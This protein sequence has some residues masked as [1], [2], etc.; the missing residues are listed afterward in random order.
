MP[1]GK[2]ICIGEEWNKKSAAEA[3]LDRDAG[4]VTPQIRQKLL[5]WWLDVARGANTPNWDLASTCEIEGRQGLLLV[6]AKAHEKELSEKGKEKPDTENG[7]KNHKRIGLAINEANAGLGRATGG[8]WGLSRD[9][10][11][12]L[13]NR[14]AWS[15][16]LALLGVPVV[17]LY[18]GFL[19]AED[20]AGDGE[21]FRSEGDWARAM[22]E[23][24]RG[25]VDDSCWENRLDVN[26][27]TL[28]PLMRVI[29]VPF[30]PD[31]DR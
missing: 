8:S 3:R 29:G 5:D 16:K 23:H 1:H 14:F 27:T 4:F 21:L 24:A 17:L 9:H 7:W 15:W 25:T 30:P 31:A 28:R 2:P 18:L 26:G 22:K 10:R 11:Y 19:N 6:E 20:M 12:Q 13:A